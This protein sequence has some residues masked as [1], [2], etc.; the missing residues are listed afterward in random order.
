M[1]VLARWSHG[2]SQ[3]LAATQLLQAQQVG[4]GLESCHS[5]VDGKQ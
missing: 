3:T 4:S 1:G 5:G 2:H